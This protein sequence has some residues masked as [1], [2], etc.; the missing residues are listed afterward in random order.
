MSVFVRPHGRSL[1]LVLS[2]AILVGAAA[3]SPVTAQ[4]YPNRPVHLYVPYPAGGPNDVIAR[5]LG[6]ELSKSFGQQMV[7]ENR[8]GGSGNIAIE[9]LARAPADG[10][11]IALPAMAYATNPSLFSKVG[12]SFDQFVPVSIVTKGPLVL[13]VH[14]SLGVKSVKELIEL[15]KS[16]PGKLDYGSGGNGSSL[17]LAAEMFKQQA[18]VDIQH[19]P[20]KGTN[21]LI[22][23]LLTGRVPISFMSPLIAKS[24]VNDGKLLALGVTSPQRSPSWPDTPTVAE[25][26]VPGYAVEAWYA[27][28]VPKDTP[29]D[30][31]ETLSKEIAKAVQS[32]AVKEKFATL[33]NESVGS[34]VAEAEKYI[35]DEADRWGKLLKANN[36]RAD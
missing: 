35:A 1:S 36:I 32:P 22:S 10:Y 33:G 13:V 8:P 16:R 34:T 3:A 4:N 5:L 30:V 12:Y 29:K 6:Q 20:Y 19:I 27:V 21:D 31:V 11:A 23:D 2:A 25:A 14:P 18:G 26:G 9:A 24:H 17:H 28:L 15:A 7:I